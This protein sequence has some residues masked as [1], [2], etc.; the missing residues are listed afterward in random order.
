MRVRNPF[1]S[2]FIKIKKKLGVMYYTA[3]FKTVFV[4]KKKSMMQEIM[5]SL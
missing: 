3:T 2:A 5:L 4:D 1:L